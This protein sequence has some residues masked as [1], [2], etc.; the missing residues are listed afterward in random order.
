VAL[1]LENACHKIADVGFVV[2]DE[3]IGAHA[4]AL[5]GS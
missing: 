5:R 3:N 1:V 4:L 2:D